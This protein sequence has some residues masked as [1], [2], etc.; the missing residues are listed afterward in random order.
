MN[1]P[2]IPLEEI[3]ESILRAFREL[4]EP[5]A[6]PELAFV[7]ATT[8]SHLEQHLTLEHTIPG[9]SSVTKCR[10][11][12]WFPTHTDDDGKDTPEEWAYAAMVGV[13]VEPLWHMILNQ[14]DECL[15]VATFLEPLDIAPGVLGMPDGQFKRLDGALLELKASGS[16]DYIYTNEQGLY[17]NHMD[18]VA[19]T[20][21]YMDGAGVDWTLIIH[22]TVAPAL[23]RWLKAPWIGEKGS[24][25]RDPDFRYPFFTLN[26]VHRN[27]EYVE[28]L[29]E[30]LVVL[31]GDQASD[32]PAPREHDPW[33]DQWPCQRMCRW[34]EMCE[35]IG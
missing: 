26:W 29:K 6:R 20:N 31:Q 7:A 12:Q 16:W 21:L 28:E 22:N 18:H 24:K 33:T 25:K 11:A 1:Q 14:A 15:K 34:R 5:T 35:G 8:P 19:Q 17:K 2:P 30:R 9:P 23:V 4:N 27:P 32:E 10:R 3:K 13:V